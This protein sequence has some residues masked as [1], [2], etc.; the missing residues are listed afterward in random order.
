MSEKYTVERPDWVPE[1]ADCKFTTSVMGGI[2]GIKDLTVG[3]INPKFLNGQGMPRRKL[4]LSEDDYVAG[5][6]RGDRM[7]L[8][9]ARATAAATSNSLSACSSGSC[10]GRARR[11][12]SA[13]Q[14][15][16]VRVSP[17]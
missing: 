6:E 13:L 3:N 7:T 9:R 4:V 14:V 16:R 8:S 11:C 15:S 17:R 2:E 1:D 5:V 12:A 10:R